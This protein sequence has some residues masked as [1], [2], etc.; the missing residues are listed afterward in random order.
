[1]I[2]YGQIRLQF[3][4]YVSASLMQVF[5]NP[6]L[7]MVFTPRRWDGLPDLLPQCLHDWGPILP[8]PDH[9]QRPGAVY[10]SL[11]IVPGACSEHALN[12]EVMAAHGFL[13]Y[14]GSK[15]SNTW[16]T[17]LAHHFLDSQENLDNCYA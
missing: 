11:V 3:L 16:I 1:M 13:R 15:R 4:L 6:F 12:T 14:I 9:N 8:T 10:D 17:E 2:T 5:S 7:P